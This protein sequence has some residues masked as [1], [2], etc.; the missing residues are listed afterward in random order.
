VARKK[1]A[2]ITMGADPEFFVRRIDTGAP[3]PICGLLGGTKDRPRM[4]GHY[5]LQEDN[6]MAEFNIPPVTD[7]NLFSA[8]ITSGRNTVLS[9]LNSEHGGIFEIDPAPSRLFPSFHLRSEQANM[10]GCSP[11]FDAY[12]LGAPNPRI[13]PL[14]LER[15]EGSWRF[16]GGHI[17]IGYKTV[18]PDLPEY[19][20]AMFCDLFLGIGMV[21]NN[22]DKQG[23]RRRY[24]G[25]P[26]RFRPTPYGLEYRTLSNFWTHSPMMVETAGYYVDAFGRFIAHGDAAIKKYWAEVP[27]QDV[28]RAISEERAD[29]AHSL[30]TYVRGLGMEEL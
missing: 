15:P 13:Q 1:K 2:A 10:F 26:G 30:V 9:I 3:H 4:V 6:V 28:R 16:C 12:M 27:W 14:E 5:G 11:D 29:L 17:H 25:T 7:I 20:A 8:H 18:A 23:E 22:F 24:Y 21:S 19:V